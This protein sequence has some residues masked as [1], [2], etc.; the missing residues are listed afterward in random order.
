MTVEHG[1]G[2]GHKVTLAAGEV[3]DPMLRAKVVGQG[4]GQRGR[5]RTFRAL[6]MFLG[7]A[8]DVVHGKPDIKVSM[9][10]LHVIAQSNLT[11]EDGITEMAGKCEIFVFDLD[12]LF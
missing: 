11:L 7:T 8:L 12:V 3:P 1:E 5:V 10:L 6:M 4:R 9:L 2:G